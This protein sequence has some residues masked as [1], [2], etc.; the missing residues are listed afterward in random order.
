MNTGQ[1]LNYWAEKQLS[2]ILKV[3]IKAIDSTLHLR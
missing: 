1:D 2:D 3:K